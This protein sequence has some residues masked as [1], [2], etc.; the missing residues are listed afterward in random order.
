LLKRTLRKETGQTAIM[1]LA[2]IQNNGITGAGGAGFPAHVKLNSKPDTIIMNAAECEPLLHKDMELILNYS[3][4]ILKGFYAVMELTGAA[5]G[6]I[7]IKEKHTHEIELLK[8]KVKGNVIVFPLE[9]VY[10][11]GDEITLIYMTTGRIVQPGKLPISA[12]CVVQNVETFYN[13][14]VNKPVVEKY[15]TVAGAVEKPATVKV[16]VGITFREVLS[17]FR[18]TEENYVVRSGG[19]MMGVLEDDLSKAVNKRTGGLIVLPADHYCVTMYNRYKTTYATDIIAKAG[20][21]QCSYCTELCPRYLLGQPVRPETAMRNRMFSSESDKVYYAGNINCCECNL[22]TMFSCPEGLD[23]RGST[24]IEKVIARTNKDNT[25][26]EGQGLHPMYNYRKVPVSS[27]KQKLDVTKYKDE[28][29]LTDIVYEPDEVKIPLNQHTG[30][31]AA[32]VVKAGDKV[33]K[34]DLIG[35]LNGVVSA[36]VHSSVTGT[37]TSVSANEVIIKRVK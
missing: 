30:A 10:P 26:F 17:K 22:C 2:E 8:S 4:E 29:P 19:L 9:D 18:I 11:A 33:Q 12:G 24:V 25:V 34:Y 6:I 37:V 3:D 36:N 32:A 14:A 23:P 13:I 28:A 1:T 35:K 31:P 5:T 16:P 27:L 7:G 15:L 20:C 21:D